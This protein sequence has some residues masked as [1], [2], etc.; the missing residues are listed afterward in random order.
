M[1]ETLAHQLLSTM[2]LQIRSLHQSLQDPSVYVPW[3][4]ILHYKSF[5]KLSGVKQQFDFSHSLRV[6][7]L[8]R[9]W[10]GS[11]HTGFFIVVVRCWLCCDHLAQL[12]W[13]SQMAHTDG[14]H[15]MLLSAGCSTGSIDVA[16]QGSCTL[17][18]ELSLSTRINVPGHRAEI[19]WEEPQNHLAS[20]SA[21][22]C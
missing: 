21:I 3:L 11:S 13:T 22:F 4:M 8:Q 10:L 16:L 2:D 1:K 14:C 12:D 7:N 20:L 18:L 5:Q 9:A 6:R 15:W 17:I 19:E